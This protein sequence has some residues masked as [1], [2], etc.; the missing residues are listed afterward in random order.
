[1]N[2]ATLHQKLKDA[3]ARH[4]YGFVRETAQAIGVSER[5]IGRWL[6]GSTFNPSYQTAEM[7][8]KHIAKINRRKKA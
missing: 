4:K 5:Q 6:A 2:P 1:M 3:H 8:A 7:L